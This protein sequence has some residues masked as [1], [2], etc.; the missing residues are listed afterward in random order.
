[1]CP[2]I[3]Y[4]KPML[5]YFE[6]YGNSSGG[7]LNDIC[8]KFRLKTRKNSIPVIALQGKHKINS[9][10][11]LA[12]AIDRHYEENTP[13]ECGIVG[14]G[15]MESMAQ[16]LFNAQSTDKGLAILLE[17]GDDIWDL[18]TC[19][20]WTFNLFAVNSFKGKLVEDVALDRFK[21][22][23]SVNYT[24]EKADEDLDC[25]A[26][27]DLVIRL[28]ASKE[29]VSG[30]QIK[31]ESFFTMNRQYVKNAV[32]AAQSTVEFPVINLIYNSNGDFTNFISI[33]SNFV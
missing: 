20:K 2:N 21:K 10:Q 14:K 17:K 26:G 32:K 7:P 22:N 15:T 6:K 12:D 28:R 29:I 18:E 25:G 13:C 33:V 8:E 24:V 27:V 5:P 9:P 30:I 1:M 31:P 16:K 11:E 19:K 4:N 23:L 3:A